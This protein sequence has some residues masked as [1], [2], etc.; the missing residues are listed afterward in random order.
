MQPNERSLIHGYAVP[1]FALSHVED[2]R[3]AAFSWRAPEGARV[4]ACALFGCAPEVV[5]S[6]EGVSGAPL[7]A[8]ANWEQC[9]LSDVSIFDSPDQIFVARAQPSRLARSRESCAP[10]AGRENGLEATRSQQLTLLGVGCWAYDDVGIIGATRIAPVPPEH[11]SDY[12]DLISAC[13][14]GDPRLSDGS[15]CYLPGPGR[16]SFGVCHGGECVA[17]CV[18]AR[19]CFNGTPT[20]SC[21]EPLATC[22]HTSDRQYLGACGRTCSRAEGGE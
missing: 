2:T 18:T 6:G 11:A 8:I 17:R 10:P 14:G 19:D 22:I 9:A 15:S 5:P 3:P 4:V 21:P 1:E 13:S 16:S 7:G 12:P 20:K